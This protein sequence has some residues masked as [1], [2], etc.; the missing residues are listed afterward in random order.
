[1][2]RFGQYGKRV[3]I[4]LGLVALALVIQVVPA[5]ASRTA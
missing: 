3:G 2:Q 1:M 4:S 5:F